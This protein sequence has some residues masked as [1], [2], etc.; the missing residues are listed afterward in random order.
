MGNAEG[1]VNA[2]TVILATLLGSGIL[3]LFLALAVVGGVW[4]YRAGGGNVPQPTPT[5][6]TPLSSLVPEDGAKVEA[7]FTALAQVC[8]YTEGVKTTGQF[9]ETYR[10]AVS[11]FKASDQLPDL[12]AADPVI[13]ARIS[14][15]IGL[16][17][18]AL[19]PQT[20]RTLVDTLRAI[21]V[22]VK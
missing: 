8:E 12:A 10:L 11:I 19:T 3:G 2:K 4:V 16:D 18:T 22:E 5:P 6:T 15:A 14:T 1:G 9:R 17:D 13:S 7:F 21:A 20:R